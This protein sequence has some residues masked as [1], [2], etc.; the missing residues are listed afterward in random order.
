MIVITFRSLNDIF[1]STGRQLLY[2]WQ[3]VWLSFILLDVLH[4][5]SK[6]FQ[7][8]CINCKRF[9]LSVNDIRGFHL[10]SDQFLYDES[11]ND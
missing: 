4:R 7:D 2:S 5:A 9:S 3:Y 1:G 10:I 6:S 11:L 8:E